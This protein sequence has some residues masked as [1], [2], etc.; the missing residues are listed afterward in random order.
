MAYKYQCSRCG[1]W[2]DLESDLCG[3]YGCVSCAGSE[4]EPRGETIWRNGEEEPEV[5]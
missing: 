4:V 2:H 1:E 5:I 3:N